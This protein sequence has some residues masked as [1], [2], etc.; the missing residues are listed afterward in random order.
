[1]HKLRFSKGRSKK[2]SR[3]SLVSAAPDSSPATT[4]TSACSSTSEQWKGAHTSSSSDIGTYFGSH[5]LTQTL[6][7]DLL[8]SVL[9]FVSYTPYEHQF[10]GISANSDHSRLYLAYLESAT[11]VHS[12]QNNHSHASFFSKQQKGGASKTRSFQ[13]TFGTLTHVLPLVCKKFCSI[14][15]S[16]DVLWSDAIERLAEYDPNGWKLAL[17]SYE[18]GYEQ[19]FQYICSD[20]R[21]KQ[22]GKNHRLCPGHAS[23]S[24]SLCKNLPET[25][26]KINPPP[27]FSS[28][29]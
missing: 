15:A 25:F 8:A 13:E 22:N 23:T 27:C 18:Q 12:P 10:A 5:S 17:S 4:S 29:V 26:R 24:T 19:E 16:S 9:S 3:F 1:M 7:D 14:C 20:A 6:N 21:T 11:K 28:N 2:A